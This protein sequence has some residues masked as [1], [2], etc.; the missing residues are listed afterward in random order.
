MLPQL[1]HA[2]DA[3]LR[4][5]QDTDFSKRERL[6][7][8]LAAMSAIIEASNYLRTLQPPVSYNTEKGHLFKWLDESMEEARKLENELSN[9]PPG[10][11]KLAPVI[12]LVP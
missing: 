6:I 9:L 11:D 3:N 8:V 1:I 5:A 12:R 4:E 10:V 2:I 7:A